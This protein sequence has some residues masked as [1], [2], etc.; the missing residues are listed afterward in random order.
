MTGAKDRPVK[1]KERIRTMAEKVEMQIREI[2]R[3]TRLRRRRYENRVIRE[4]TVLCLLL[5]AASDLVLHH[6]QKPG[7]A[8]V[9][10]AYGTVLLR[11]G[12]GAYIVVGIV[13]F[14]V[15]VVLTVLCSRYRK[16]KKTYRRI[17]EEGEE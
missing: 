6:V 17:V 12:A 10:D 13:A 15:G 5:L 14:V 16:G 11:D 2:H 9:R 4:L 7:M 3:R 1:K 8:A